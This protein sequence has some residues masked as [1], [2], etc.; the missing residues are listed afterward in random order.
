MPGDRSAFQEKA[1]TWL[2]KLLTIPGIAAAAIF[3][4]AVSWIATE[5]LVDV[6]ARID[7]RE[8]VAIAVTD[9]PARIGA[10]S[11]QP[12]YGMIPADVRTT[13]NPGPGCTG[14]HDWLKANKGIDAGH[15]KLRLVVQGKVSTPILLSEMR[16]KVLQKRPLVSGIPVSCPPAAEVKY[17]PI[18]IDLDAEPPRVTYQFDKKNF[19]FTLQAGETEAFNII[20]TTT[21]GHYTW[22]IELDLVVDGNQRTIEVPSGPFET[23]ARQST[24]NWQWDY[25]GGWSSSLETPRAGVPEKIS[26]ETPLPPLR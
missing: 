13:G 26:A 15:T 2:K 5:F 8:P 1:R 22:L 9:N 21:K 23:T 18:E 24:D 19:G 10:F 11:D 25:D 14:F 3:T 12:I 6:R 7:V 16:V 17:R 20:A 4:T